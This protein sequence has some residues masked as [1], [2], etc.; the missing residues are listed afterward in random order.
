MESAEFVN[1]KETAERDYQDQ[2]RDE[3]AQCCERSIVAQAQLT[4]A[5]NSGDWLRASDYLDEMGGLHKTLA[6]KFRKAALRREVETAPLQKV[7]IAVIHSQDDFLDERLLEKRSALPADG[8]LVLFVKRGV[9]VPR[10]LVCLHTMDLYYFDDTDH[11]NGLLSAFVTTNDWKIDDR[12]YV[13]IVG[14]GARAMRRKFEG[15]V[16]QEKT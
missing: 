4:Y 16:C 5:L 2:L 11:F 9:V 8:H 14:H 13:Q 10:G 3:I 1:G 12:S 7:L 6:R 15:G